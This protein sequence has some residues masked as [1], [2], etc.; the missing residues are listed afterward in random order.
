MGYR[1]SKITMSHVCL[2]PAILIIIY[3]L[4]FSVKVIPVDSPLEFRENVMVLPTSLLVH[5]E[6]S[7]VADN[8]PAYTNVY[9]VLSH[10]V[11]YP[12][13][14][15][16]GSSFF[17]HRL[18][19][20]I[21][22]LACCGIIFK[23][24]RWFDTPRH[25]SICALSF[26]LYQMVRANSVS[27]FPIAQ[28]QFFF[29]FSLIIPWKLRF[30]TFS[31]VAS[32]ALSILALLTKPYFV[33]GLPII[34]IYLF[35][36]VSKKRAILFGIFSL[37]FATF[38][39]WQMSRFFPYYF[40]NTFWYCITPH[41]HSISYL[42]KQIDDYFDETFAMVI[43]VAFI[44]IKQLIDVR[45]RLLATPE[46]NYFG[47]ICN[48][49]DI[50][51]LS[52]PFI[53]LPIGLMPFVMAVS[54][55]SLLKLGQ[56]HGRFFGYFAELLTPF[57]LILVFPY[58]GNKLK[59][60]RLVLILISLN[61]FL[62]LFSLPDWPADN[63]KA[64]AE[65]ETIISEHKRVYASPPLAHILYKQ[66]KPVYEIGHSSSL[67]TCLS[68][69]PELLPAKAKDT[70]QQYCRDLQTKVESQYFDLIIVRSDEKP[71]WD[72]GNTIQEYYVPMQEKV[73]PMP[74]KWKLQ[75]WEPRG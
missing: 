61:L 53:N 43:I 7:F 44:A 6:N 50:R 60:N 2:L 69:F 66:G 19:S 31:L 51:H 72:T 74:K 57:L 27:A 18:V 67:S 65:W 24:L 39:L 35:I 37:I 8:Q 47:R 20:M 28:G 22:V 73:L 1:F 21:F 15:I 38:V 34:A 58:V 11:V 71:F 64:W 12:L 52:R 26:F 4:L 36:A 9:G 41:P 42:F 33:L 29:L 70:I 13:A 10:I 5:G 75:L 54:V 62:M 68:S 46:K 55:L 45:Q 3:E 40:L 23:T 59:D 30:S 56:H 16:F 14:K 48:L 63:R 17:I 49:F 32:A 25:L